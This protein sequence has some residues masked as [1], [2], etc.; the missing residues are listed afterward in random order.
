[1]IPDIDGCQPKQTDFLDWKYLSGKQK[2]V[3]QKMIPDKRLDKEE[4][5]VKKIPFDLVQTNDIH[6]FIEASV[7]ATIRTYIAEF[8]LKS[9]PILTSLEFNDDNYDNSL[10]QMIVAHM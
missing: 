5:C 7:L 6:G 9:L 4:E 2:H 10:S 8:I 3:A 1:M